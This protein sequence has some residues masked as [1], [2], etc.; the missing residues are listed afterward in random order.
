MRIL[1]DAMGSDQYPKPEVD[2]AYL[3]AEE[4]GETIGLVGNR[5]ILAPLLTRSNK[6]IEIIQA[7]EV[8]KMTDKI[9]LRALRTVK[10]SMGVAYDLMKCGEGDAFVTLGNT[11]GAMA[12]GLVRLGRI[13]GVLRPALSAPFPVKNGTCIVLDIGANSECKPEYLLQLPSWV[14]PMPN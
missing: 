9:S 3:A 11:G 8:F 12:I 4:F 6:N 7:D 10:N 5:D 1:L 14:R 2:A 13:K